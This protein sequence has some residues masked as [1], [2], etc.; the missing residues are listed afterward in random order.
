MQHTTDVE[1]AM[2]VTQF[3]DSKRKNK[4]RDFVDKQVDKYMVIPQVPKP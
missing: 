4:I 2:A 3:L 1:K